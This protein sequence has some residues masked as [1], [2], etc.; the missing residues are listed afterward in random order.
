[1]R[2]LLLIGGSI[3][4]VLLLAFFGGIKLGQV[5]MYEKL[6]FG[7]EHNEILVKVPYGDN[8]VLVKRYKDQDTISILDPGSILSAETIKPEI[9][10]Q[11][12]KIKGIEKVDLKSN[13]LVLVKIDTASWEDLIKD[14]LAVLFGKK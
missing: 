5:D 10:L 8:N 9:G 13:E 6:V 2:R 14:V 12:D 3:V 11:L 4:V 7:D 1:M